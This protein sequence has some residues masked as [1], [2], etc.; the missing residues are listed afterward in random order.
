MV[1]SDVA[2]Q[3]FFGSCEQRRV[4]SVDDRLDSGVSKGDAFIWVGVMEF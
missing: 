2:T 4:V 1:G 3:S